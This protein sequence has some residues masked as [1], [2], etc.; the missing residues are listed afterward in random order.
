MTEF[1]RKLDTAKECNY[2]AEF[3]FFIFLV[4][5]TDSIMDVDCLSMQQNS[6]HICCEQD[7]GN[8]C[9]RQCN[10]GFCRC[11]DPIT[12]QPTLDALFP[13]ND[14]SIDCSTSESLF[15]ITII[16]KLTLF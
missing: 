9:E 14:E 10:N 8:F 6:P 7:T 11:V 4:I 15:L 1:V 13:E 2:T 5:I 16:M 3:F 12:G